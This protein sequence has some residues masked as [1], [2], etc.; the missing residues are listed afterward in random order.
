MRRHARRI[1]PRYGQRRAQHVEQVGLPPAEAAAHGRDL[2]CRLPRPRRTH[3]GALRRVTRPI[4]S[5]STMRC[6]CAKPGSA[7]S[8]FIRV[9]GAVAYRFWSAA[10]RRA[11]ARSYAPSNCAH[12]RQVLRRY[13]RRPETV[14]AP[15]ARQ[16][17]NHAPSARNCS[18]DS[19]RSSGVG[20]SAAKRA[21][22]AGAIRVNADVA[23]KR[24]CR[25]ADVARDSAKASRGPRQRCAAEIQR[26]AVA[27]RDDLDAIRIEQFVRIGDRRRQRRHRRIAFGQRAGHRTNAAG[28]ASG[29]SPCRLTTIVSSSQPNCSAHSARRSLPEA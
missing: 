9:G 17:D 28:G 10:Q 3:M 19:A 26:V 23:Q 22:E 6:A 8:A 29:S 20:A 15:V 21:Q 2:P 7:A 25:T 14:P 13:P 5:C 4:S 1:D 18:S 27:V 16:C 24:Q 11:K 12:A